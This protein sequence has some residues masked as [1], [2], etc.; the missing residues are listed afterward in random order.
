M[1]Q[2]ASLSIA[3]ITYKPVF[4]DNFDC[5]DL[6]LGEAEG[7][8]TSYHEL[9]G[10]K[11][12]QV[13]NEEQQFYMDHQED[14]P[15][16]FSCDAGILSITAAKADMSQMEGAENYDI[17]SGLITS[18]NSFQ[19]QYGYAEISAKLPEGQGFWPAFWMLPTSGRW[20]NELDV[21]EI[22]GDRPERIFQNSHGAGSE[23]LSWHDGIDWSADYHTYGLLWTETHLVWTIDGEVTRIS[24]SH[25]HEP[26]YLLANLAVGGKWPGAVDVN[27][28]DLGQMDIDFIRVWQPEIDTRIADGHRKLMLDVSGD[29]FEGA[30]QMLV[31]L[32]GEALHWQEVHAQKSEGEID[33]IAIDLPDYGSEARRL[34][35][36]FLNDRWGGDASSDRN[37]YIHQARIDDQALDLAKAPFQT[38]HET[39]ASERTDDG[40][41]LGRTGGLSIDV[42]DILRDDQSESMASRLDALRPGD[43]LIEQNDSPL[44]NALDNVAQTTPL[45][46]ELFPDF[47]QTASGQDSALI[48]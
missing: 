8:K 33:R 16:P 35:I 20:T 44:S 38:R 43:K 31:R 15:S 41:V 12:T 40:I 46:T 3:G 25:V 32:D 13:S 45:G 21:F 37:L 26:M 5:L 47:I 6:S 39:F 24:P 23:D 11:R 19:F 10:N 34:D 42:Q 7:W 22:L 48:H 30:P 2:S 14:G 4:E 28:F 17:A 18:E 1:T 9:G 29:M 27:E 36:A